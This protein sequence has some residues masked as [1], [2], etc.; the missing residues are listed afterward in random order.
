MWDPGKQY[1]NELIETKDMQSPY[2]GGYITKDAALLSFVD[3]KK[4]YTV[5]FFFKKNIWKTSEKR[6]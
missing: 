3:K 6:I 4:N 5:G 2:L 1:A